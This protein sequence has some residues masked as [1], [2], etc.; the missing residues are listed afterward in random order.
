M[1]GEENN[2]VQIWQRT[3][4]PD[5]LQSVNLKY[6]KLGYHYL[7]SHLLT[8]CLI[9]LMSVIVVEASRL[10]LDDVHQL[11]LQLQYNLVSFI[12][13]SVVL[14]FGS[15]VYIMTR[16]RSVYLL[17]YSCYLPPSHLKVKYQQ[18]MEHSK[19]T[20]DFDESSLEFQRKI[21]ER[22]GLGEET[23]V[24]EAMHYLPPRPSMAA[25]REEAEQVMFGALDKL[26]ANTNVKPRDIGILV[27]NCSLFN[28]TPSLSAMIINKYKLRGNIRSFNLGGMGCSAGVIAI[29]LAK[30]MLQVHRNSYAVVVSTENI[31]QN[32]YFG[33][34]KSMLIPNC[35]FRVG[36]AAVLLTNRSVDRRRSKYKLVH[37]VRTHCGANDKAFKCVYQEQDD[38]GKTGV[39]LSKDLMAIAGGALKT[40][41]TTLGPL[42]LPISEQIL[43]FV[44]LVAKKLFNAKI[45]PYIP[46]FKLAF[47]HFCIH[48]GGRAVI[49]E[50]E[51]NLQLLPVHAEASRMTLHRF[52]NTSSSS[53]W[54][55]L[56]YTEAK[57]RMRKGNRVWQIAF[58][59]GF[60]CNSTVWVALRNVKPSPNN[61]WEDCI[62]RYPV[63]LNL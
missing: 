63:Q 42:V 40:N 32:W 4:L 53:I 61:P 16:P 15:T 48:A 31:T 33:N 23:C 5:F 6:V 45:K 14:V 60:K 37:V 34:K 24:P 27:V 52:G 8:L 12:V 39:S 62:H 38:N 36:G 47:D 9:P 46:D 10:S 43:F 28:P 55:E 20:G 49:D 3:R 1:N 56:A 11:W 50:L 19:L 44:T 2:R 59:S 25:A 7:I 17:D 26:F 41:I 18:F 29:D 22:S 58:G 13:F 51:K 30:D 35:L 57:G 54:Y 21:L